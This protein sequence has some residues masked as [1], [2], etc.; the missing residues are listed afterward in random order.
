MSL[1][2]KKVI[3]DFG[4]VVIMLVGNHAIIDGNHAIIEYDDSSLMN[5]KRALIRQ[6]GM[7]KWLA[8][9]NLWLIIVS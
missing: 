1:D 5:I 9:G 3:Q 2:A 6:Q 8:F 7:Q 4:S